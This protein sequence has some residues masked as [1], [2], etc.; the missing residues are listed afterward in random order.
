MPTIIDALVVSL[1]LDAKAV[2]KGQ[3][4]AEGAFKQVEDSAKR[5]GDGIDN[6]SSKAEASLGKVEKGAEK[7][8]DAMEDGGK[9]SDD[10]LEKTE[11]K[12]QKV[13]GHISHSGKEASEFFTKMQKQA[14]A[15]FAVLTTGKSLKAFTSDTINAGATLGRTARR[16]NMAKRDVYALQKSVESVGGSGDAA[17]AALQNMQTALTDPQQ[18]AQIYGKLQQLGV[19]EGID[20][21]TGQITDPE[22]FYQNLAENRTHQANAPRVGLLQ[23][24]NFDQGSIDLI[25]KGG[26]AVKSTF[27]TYRELGSHIEANADKTEKLQAKY[28]ELV[29]QNRAYA[30]ELDGKLLPALTAVTDA[31]TKLGKQHPLIVQGAMGTAAAIAGIGAAV[32]GV[33]S[34]VGGFKFLRALSRIEKMV[35]AAK[36]AKEGGSV[37]KEGEKVTEGS[38]KT[39]EK[40]A[41]AAAKAGRIARIGRIASRALGGL[42][43]AGDAYLVGDTF[44][45]G[46]EPPLS[47]DDGTGTAKRQYLGKLERKY[48][49]P[50][51]VLDAMWAQES[52]RGKN[53]RPSSAGALGEFQIMPAV[54]RAEGVDA[55]DF[56][57]SADY[58]ARRMSDNLHKYHGSLAASLADYNWGGGN[59]RKDQ[60]QNGDDWLSHAPN[61]TQNYVTSISHAVE[62]AQS[63]PQGGS[64]TVAPINQTTVQVGEIKVSSNSPEQAAIAIQQKILQMGNRASAANSG[65]S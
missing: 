59:V 50:A 36:V 9:K 28:K 18:S 23:D 41:P 49:L 39:A 42:N 2:V 63:M 61:E 11:K 54:A 16:M 22:K 15:F 57:Q 14:L 1:G 10:A 26:N 55:N 17:T 4:Q 7:A 52:S 29:E 12:A 32:L 34:I 6:S 20:Y 64:G 43:L 51:G 21:Q 56:K 25:L 46:A 38:A 31:F 62:A 37:A 13:A 48:G 35:E 30:Q 5:M 45:N 3:K 40:A 58:A 19:S 33:M 24:L 47:K 8:A 60:R 44:W 65:V 27:S 53:A